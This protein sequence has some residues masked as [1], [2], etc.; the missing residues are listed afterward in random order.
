MTNDLI[1]L[2]GLVTMAL[3]MLAYSLLICWMNGAFNEP[4]DE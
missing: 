2:A 1:V 4:G 3:G